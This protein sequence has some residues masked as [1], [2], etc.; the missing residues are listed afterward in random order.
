MREPA[1]SLDSALRKALGQNGKGKTGS[2]DK[3][4]STDKQSKPAA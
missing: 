4:D 3:T 2:D 1:K